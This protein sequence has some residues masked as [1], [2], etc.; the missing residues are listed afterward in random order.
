MEDLQPTGQ[1]KHL[2]TRSP[3]LWLW[4]VLVVVAVVSVLS[5]LGGPEHHAGIGERLPALELEP[6]TGNPPR[7]S[8]ADLEGSVVLLN[9]WGPWCPPCQQELPHMAALR[10][11]FA[12]QKAFRLVAIS[13][14]GPDGE[15]RESLRT[16]TE[17]VLKELKIDLPTYC[18]PTG[19]TQSAV[20]RV[21][22][23]TGYP[24]TLLLDR[25]GIIRAVWVGYRSGMETKME[26]NV[27]KILAETKE[28]R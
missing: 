27:D 16:S 4:V 26:R 28:Q 2:R 9:F 3:W 8:L 18:D 23:F 11:H 20:D 7:L 21:V 22:G 12:D 14:P 1:M 25:H 15:D 17:A 13:Y 5:F 10:E 24:T 6:L 19:V